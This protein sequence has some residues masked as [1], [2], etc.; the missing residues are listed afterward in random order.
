[1]IARYEALAERR[2]S[3]LVRDVRVVRST[4]ILARIGYLTRRRPRTG[5]AGGSV[6]RP[7]P[8]T[9]GGCDGDDDDR[10]CSTSADDDSLGLVVDDRRDWREVVAESDRGPPH[11]Q[12]AP[13]TGRS[14]S[15]C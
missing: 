12:P 2:A 3:R 6:R 11:S 9:E 8:R 5:D 10:R 13:R 4:A 1:L 14:T 7:A 15:G